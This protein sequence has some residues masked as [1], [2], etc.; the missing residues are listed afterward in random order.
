MELQTIAGELASDNV[1][2]YA[3]SSD[4]PDVLAAFAAKYDITYPL[5]SDEG[6]ALIRQLGLLNEEAPE[7]VFGIPHP[8]IF[9]LDTNGTIVEKHFY[10]S[11]RER[12]TGSGL[13]QHVLGFE[14]I[15]HG[16]E[17]RAAS[18]A[19]GVRAWFDSPTYRW[20]QRLWLT[21]GLTIAPGLHV[22]GRPIPEGYTP[23]GIMI[24]PIERVSVGEPVWPP[25]RPFRIAGLDEQF[26]IYEETIRVS[27]PITFMTVDSGDLTVRATVSFQAC[28]ASDCL[29]PSS[30]R[31]E[32]RLPEAPLIERPAPR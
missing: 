14:R 31:V 9:V 11:Y 7:A 15:A 20:G 12:D 22:Y 8:G 30:A 21:V 6:S 4:A 16:P 29:L 18:D 13:L 25:T 23:L 24:D 32:L 19:V 26:Q 17:T 1:A 3:I 27:L 28:T 2:L 10:D 5:L